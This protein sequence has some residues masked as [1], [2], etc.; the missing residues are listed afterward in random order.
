MMGSSAHIET[1]QS[2]IATLS[3]DDDCDTTSS[4]MMTHP[5]IWIIADGCLIAWTWNET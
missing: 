4:G 3:M 2:S 1:L 5:I